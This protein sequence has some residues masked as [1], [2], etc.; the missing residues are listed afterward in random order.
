MKTAVETIFF[1]KGRLY[2]RRFM[3]MCSHYLV[4]PVACMPASGWEMGH[5]KNQ[6][7]LVRE[8]FFTPRLRFKHLD[9]PNA[10]LLDKCI[11]CAKAHPHPELAEQTIWEVFEAERPKLV[12]YAGRF[13]GFHALTA[14]VSKTCLVRFDNN[15]YSV[16]AS[17]VGRPVEAQ[18][19][20]DRIVIRQDGSIVAEHPRS[21]GCR[22]ETT[23][24]PWQYV[25]VLAR[26][27]GA[28]RNGAPSRTGTPSSDRADPAQADQ[29]R[30]WQSR[31]TSPMRAD[32][33]SA[34]GG[35]RLCRSGQGPPTSRSTSWP[36]NAN[37]LH[38][39]H[40]D[41]G[42][43]DAP[44]CADR[45]LCPLRQPPEDLLMERTQIFDLMGELKLYG[46]KAA[47]DEVM[48][49]TIKRQHDLSASSA[50]CATPR[51]TR[52]RP[53]RSSTSSPL[54]SCRLPRISPPSN[55]KARQ[56]TKR[57]SPILPAVASSLSSTTSSWS[58]ARA[59][60]RPIWP[61]QLPGAASDQVPVAASIR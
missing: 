24:D 45:R 9:E 15:K 31:S 55:S 3:Q 59:P 27:P 47:F 60:A 10:W 28:L 18:G 6:I 52:S 32:G 44:S 22:G 2:D 30:R 23:Y 42:R 46:M 53:G 20:A 37:P 19:Y 12:P 17:A 16:A 29:H 13:D 34:G 5:V 4:D 39:K 40:H 58:A 48:A 49:N 51:S 8:R 7:G 25:P 61:S 41:A 35:S 38:R 36:R 14:S 11:A 50:T 57:S 21:F 1:G 54:P 33:R 56:S 26:K 43:T